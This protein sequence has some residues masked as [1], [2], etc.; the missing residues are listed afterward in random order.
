MLCPNRCVFCWR[1]TNTLTASSLEKIDEPGQIIEGCVEKQREL[2]NGFPGNPKLDKTKFKQAQDPVSFALSLTGE[3]TIY[4]RL[5][6]LL[7]ELKK[8][9]KCSFL[10]S[11]GQFPEKIESLDTL[12]TQLYISLDAP[13]QE[14]Y[15]KI[16]KP[17]LSDFW[18]RFNKTLELLPSLDTR[19][20]LRITAVKGLNSSN[21]KDYARLINKADPMFV[22]VKSYSWVGASRKR[23]ED[24]NVFQ[25]NEIIDFSEQL[26]KES[27]FV[28][29][30]QKKESRVTLLMREDT[31]K[32]FLFK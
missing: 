14:L 2:L 1:D 17:T 26:A 21:L 19:K 25:H 6:D 13:T 4:P 30:D 9:N 3:P 29:V 11:N 27:G 18:Q 12:P 5:G 24:N 7:E 23:L 32:R 8:R 20:V 16:D 31:K 15:K 10:V 28:V 22:E